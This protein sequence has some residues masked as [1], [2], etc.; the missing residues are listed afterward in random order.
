[1]EDRH[2]YHPTFLDKNGAG[3]NSEDEL[4]KKLISTCEEGLNYNNI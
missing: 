2:V 3:K 1:M 4:I